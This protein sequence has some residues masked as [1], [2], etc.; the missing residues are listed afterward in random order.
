MNKTK[1]GRRCFYFQELSVRDG[2]KVDRFFV[3]IYM[4]LRDVADVF[5]VYDFFLVSYY[6][7]RDGVFVYFRGDVAIYLNV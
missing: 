6:V 5:D 4:F 7:Y 2:E 1:A 3:L